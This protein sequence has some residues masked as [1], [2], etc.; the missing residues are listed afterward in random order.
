MTRHPGCPVTSAEFACMAHRL[1][2]RAIEPYTCKRC[3]HRYYVAQI[4]GPLPVYEDELPPKLCGKCDPSGWEE[5]E[6]KY[7][8]RKHLE[9]AEP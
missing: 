8:K 7:T 9:V 3:G 2:L 6:S 4:K 5:A 1:K